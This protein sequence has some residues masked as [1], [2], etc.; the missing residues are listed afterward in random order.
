MIGVVFPLTSTLSINSQGSW[1]LILEKRYGLEDGVIGP[2][3]IDFNSNGEFYWTSILTGEVAG[4]DLKGNNIYLVDKLLLLLNK[5]NVNT[6][7]IY[8]SSFDITPNSSIA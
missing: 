6:D 1:W 5:Y 4:F 7:L 3:D 8:I 2:D